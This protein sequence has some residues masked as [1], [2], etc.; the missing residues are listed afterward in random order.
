MTILIQ[1]IHKLNKTNKCSIATQDMLGSDKLWKGLKCRKINSFF[2]KKN[3]S[4][5]T[6]AMSLMAILVIS[7]VAV[8]FISNV[9]P[10]KKST[11]AEGI[12]RKYMLK[13]EQKG[14]LTPDNESAMINDFNNIGITN[15]DISGT[16]LTQVNYGEDVYLHI[17]YKYHVRSITTNGGLIPLFQD[18]DKT[19]IIN[20]SSTSKKAN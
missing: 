7:F 12:A 4:V 2:N 8:Y 10:I 19:A 3:G 9:V 18:V 13:M 11:D 5:D 14:Y 20:K 16:T 17:S 1:D 6:V 15:I